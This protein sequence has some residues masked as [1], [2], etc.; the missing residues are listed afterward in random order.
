MY[1]PDAGPAELLEKGVAQ[2]S[3]TPTP[4]KRIGVEALKQISRAVAE[5]PKNRS[6]TNFTHAVVHLPSREPDSPIVTARLAVERAR[7]ST[8]AWEDLGAILSELGEFAE[9]CDCFETALRLNP[10]SPSAMN[11]LGVALQR[12]G[13]LHEA[14]SRYREAL[15][16]RPDYTQ[17]QMNLASIRGALGFHQ[18]ALNVINQILSRNAYMVAALRLAAALESELGR[19]PTALAW[20]ERASAA[21]PGN[22]ETLTQRAEI[23]LKLGRCEAALLDCEQV[24][25]KSPGASK[26]L[27]IRALALKGLNRIS[28]ALEAFLSAEAFSPNPASI[29]ADRAWLLAEMGQRDEAIVTFD[30][31]LSRQPDLTAAWGHRAYLTQQVSQSDLAAMERIASNPDRPHQDRVNLAFALGQAYLKLGDGAKAFAHLELGNRLKRATLDYDWAAEECR[32]SNIAAVFS[33]ETLSRFAGCGDPSARP[34]FVFGMPRSGTSLV[35]QILAS[36]GEVNGLGELTHLSDLVGTSPNQQLSAIGLSDLGRQYL[37]LIGPSEAG[38]SR[39]VDKMTWNFLYAGLISLILPNAR[40]IHCRRNPLDT[41]LSSYSILFSSGHPYSYDL[42]ELGHFYRLYED[43]MV[44]WRGVLSPA[45]FKEV[46]Y[47]MLVEDTEGEVHKLLEFL[48]LPWDPNCLQFHKTRRRVS[49][50]SLDQVRS[51]I[52]NTSRGRAAQFRPWLGP[53]EA[54]LAKHP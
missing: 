37:E 32:S 21:E 40:M 3:I 50:A 27:H 10:A 47:E 8:Q 46:E 18:D 6:L 48:E 35:E 19:L 51:P 2:S 24:I 5:S 13:R 20:I 29:I 33:A 22:D 14:E 39:F 34:I 17:V 4:F 43:L 45:R 42:S 26:A 36:H 15:Q 23:L 25:G 7:N 31:A 30:Q 28:E 44:H 12:L 52:Y 16:V 38:K 9:S 53:L 41:C 1:D 54:A 49:S 11:N